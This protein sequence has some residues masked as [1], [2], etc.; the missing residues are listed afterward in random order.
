[1]SKKKNEIKITD[2]PNGDPFNFLGFGMVAYRDLLTTLIM[3]FA[4][5]SVFMTPAIAFYRKGGAIPNPVGY[6]SYTLGNMGYSH[7]QCQSYPFEI[8]KITMFCSFG[9][10]SEIFY[11]G[12]NPSG[13]KDKD[14][15][16]PKEESM[17]C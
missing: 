10:I 13:M 12:I 9:T 5:L 2:E 8:N 6:M 1:M 17:I 16:A 15:C 11:L 14:A 7:T 4:L 3:L